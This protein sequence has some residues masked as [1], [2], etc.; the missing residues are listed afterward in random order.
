MIQYLNKII[1]GDQNLKRS[2]QSLWVEA[3][4]IATAAKGNIA[5]AYEMVKK[6]EAGSVGIQTIIMVFIA[7]VIIYQLIP[8][9]SA[10]NQTVQSSANVSTMGKFAAGL[11]EWMFPLLG[12]IALV[13]LFVRSR[14]TTA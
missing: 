3:I 1:T 4:A 12:I 2:F 10:D 5:V 7:I 6:M 11:G 8:T 9:L 14:K 13:F